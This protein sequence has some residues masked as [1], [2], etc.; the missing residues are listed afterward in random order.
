MTQLGHRT[1]S[2]KAP[3][4]VPDCVIGIFHSGRIM[5]LGS[6]QP[7]N[8]NEYQEYFLG[9][10]GGRCV[11]LRTL[12]PPGVVC[13]EIGDCQPP[14]TFWECYN[15]LLGSLY[16]HVY[17]NCSYDTHK[18][19]HTHTLSHTHTHTYIYIYIRGLLEKYPTVFFY[20]NT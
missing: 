6:T 11:G 9:V 1:T 10:E 12:P 3:G 20:A 14:G 8:I 17:I 15:S 7:H 16:L 5:V 13:V 2:R 19:I 4:S 18:N